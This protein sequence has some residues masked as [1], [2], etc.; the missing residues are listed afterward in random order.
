[1]SQ[2]HSRA[3]PP[4]T[5][6]EPPLSLWRARTLA[7]LRDTV[8]ASGGATPA[9][10]EALL[11]TM[12]R[13]PRADEDPRERADVLLSLLDVKAPAGN[14]A[15]LDGRTV[16]E[17]AVE[18]LLS[19]GYPH[20]LE[21]PPEAL[22]QARREQHERRFGGSTFRAVVVTVLAA[23]AQLFVSVLTLWGSSLFEPHA[24]EPLGA[25][26]SVLLGA[27]LLPALLA[28][29]GRLLDLRGLQWLGSKGLGLQCMLWA[30]IASLS[31]ASFRVEAILV[32][33]LLPWHLTWY[34]ARLTKP[35]RVPKGPGAGTRT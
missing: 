4:P 19:L 2:E 24:R 23:L 20:A 7:E 13:P 33:L 5:R 26:W 25:V 21:V 1:M 3:V 12:A 30:G 31:L 27:S 8:S 9:D 28:I 35:A 15:G 16:R 22:E 14:L 6:E 34:A 10:V 17:G 29:T 11:A 32:A 18:A